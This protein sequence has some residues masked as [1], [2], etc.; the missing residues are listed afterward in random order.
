MYTGPDRPG[1]LYGMCIE[2]D[3]E[4]FTSNGYLCPAPK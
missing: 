2:C 4:T 3:T 1:L